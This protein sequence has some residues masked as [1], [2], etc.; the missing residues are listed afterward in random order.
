MSKP[1]KTGYNGII[2]WS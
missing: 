2:L 1:D